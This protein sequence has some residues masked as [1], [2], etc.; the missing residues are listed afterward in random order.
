MRISKMNR[1]I[2]LTPDRDNNIGGYNT[3]MLDAPSNRFDVLQ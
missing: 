2:Y 1:K 3:L